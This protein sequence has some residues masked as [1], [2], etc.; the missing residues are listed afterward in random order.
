MPRRLGTTVGVC[1]LAGALATLV[2][3]A[4][5]P[6]S[7]AASRAPA[8]APVASGQAATG[9]SPVAFLDPRKGRT[10]TPIKHLVVI[11][12]ENIS[13]D[14]YFGTYPKATNKG[15][16]TKF[17]AKKNTPRNDNL[18]TSKKLKKNPNLYKPFRLGPKQALT[19]DQNHGYTAEQK[20][21][22]L[23]HMDQ[24]VQNVSVDTCSGPFGAPGLTMGYFDG[25]TVTGLWNYAQNFAMSD[26]SFADNF[27]PSTPGAINLVSGNTHGFVEVDPVTGAPATPSSQLIDHDPTTGV[28][29]M[30]G[31]PQPY[32]D[33]C[34]HHAGANLV[35]GTGR[36]IGDLLNAKG[37]TWGWF[38]GGFTPTSPWPG[39][40]GTFATCGTTHQ[41]VGGGSSIDYIPHHNPF[42]YYPSTANP[43]HL[44]PSSIKAVGTTDQANHN[45]DLSVFAQAIKNKSLPA[46]SFLKARAFE[47]GHAGY[48]S[49][50][51]EQ[52]FLVEQI[53]LIQKSK[54]WKDTAIV[55]AYDDSDGW[56]DHRAAK[57]THGSHNATLDTPLC[58]GV[59]AAGGYTG[60]C[61]P[62]PR[63]PLLVLSPYARA[64]F[65]DHHQTTQSSI[66][67][68][69]EDNWKVG[70]IGDFSFDAGAGSL[71]H[72]FDFKQRRTIQLLL[73]PNGAVKRL[74]GK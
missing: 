60:R 72:L 24:F 11:F 55:I 3:G 70:R 65:V 49:P 71:K 16:G 74:R 9:V 41:N 73:K 43:H 56:Y 8:P 62:G 21:H 52:R 26:R 14:H 46:V 37:I 34:S 32:H 48:S 7:G 18:I 68:F 57:I 39:A 2:V 66:L 53:N 44:P 15:G 35:V 54:Y 58:S 42:S 50:L 1:A 17:R 27:G 19:C 51:D 22:N 47:D 61:G 28:G 64:N 69:I 31:D 38:Q 4:T 30:I 10:K 25:N 40:P 59:P 63:L 20:A 33:D 23:G 67:R 36:N 13:Y 5:V 45:Y 6:G 12:D 29:S